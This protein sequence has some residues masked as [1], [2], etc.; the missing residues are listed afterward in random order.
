M[1]NDVDTNL[2][3]VDQARKIL[4]ARTEKLS[5]EQ[6]TK[7]LNMLRLLCD[8]QIDS[9]IQKNHANNQDE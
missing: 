8:K 2:I 5:D 3:T 7:L 4:G 6:I 9:S 1:S